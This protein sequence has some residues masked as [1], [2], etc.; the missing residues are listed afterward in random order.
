MARSAALLFAART[1]RRQQT[2]IS[3]DI[4]AP[5]PSPA[6]LAARSS[7]RPP[8]P[9]TH[10]IK[11]HPTQ[12]SPQSQASSSISRCG[13]YPLLRTYTKGQIGLTR[14][15]FPNP[16][17]AA[18]LDFLPTD[19][20]DDGRSQSPNDYTAESLPAAISHREVRF[21]KLLRASQRANKACH[22][23]HPIREI[24]PNTTWGDERFQGV[25]C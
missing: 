9:A 17:S 19:C 11:P 21:E 5:R 8:T 14:R 15:R 12:P 1:D 7:G 25:A 2:D 6:S 22:G 20:S 24:M 18:G 13:I 23:A 10:A 3:P 4:L 16:T